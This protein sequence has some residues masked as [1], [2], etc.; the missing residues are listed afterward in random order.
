MGMARVLTPIA[1]NA[2]AEGINRFH[3]LGYW[4]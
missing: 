4:S 1:T 2:A 3:D